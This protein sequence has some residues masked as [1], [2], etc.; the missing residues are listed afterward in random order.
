MKKLLVIALIACLCSTAAAQKSKRKKGSGG[1]VPTA[2]KVIKSSDNPESPD[3]AG[4]LS[5][6]ETDGAPAPNANAPKN[7]KSKNGGG[8]AIAKNRAGKSSDNPES[9]DYAGL[10]PDTKAIAA[11]QR[12]SIEPSEQSAV[13][14]KVVIAPFSEPAGS[15]GR[16]AVLEIFSEQND[17]EMVG[18]NDAEIVAKRL[19][20][21]LGS[22]KGRSVVSADMG[23]YAW[24]DGRVGDGFDAQI[25][26]SDA[27]SRTL[28]NAQIKADSAQ[29]LASL[30]RTDLWRQVGPEIS[31]R[32]KLQQRYENQ[33]QL[34]AQT[35]AAWQKE[36]N[37]QGELAVQ[38]QQRRKEYL[39]AAQTAAMQK[40]K[41]WNDQIAHQGQLAQERKQAEALEARR[42]QEE[43]ARQA[44]EMQRQQALEQQRQAA[45][46]QAARQAA[47]QEAARQ[48]AAEQAAR[49]QAA[50]QAALQAQ[51]AA[52]A[53]YQQQP[54]YQQPVYQQPVYRQPSAYQQPLVA[55]QGNAATA[56]P[57]WQVQPAQNQGGY[58]LPSTGYQQ[59][60]AQ[61]STQPYPAAQPAQPTWQT[62]GQPAYQQ[63]AAQS[64]TQT[65]WQIQPQP[66]A[67]SDASADNSSPKKAR[68]T[69]KK[70]RK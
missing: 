69:K 32:A 44:A 18:Y 55:G 7:K 53:Q 46:E 9:P 50:R 3:F 63:P 61:G 56:Q 22:S 43:A 21:D 36:I 66:Y 54:V 14:R 5:E 58:Q 17:I 31:D 52:Q 15:K 45:A 39:V 38:R 42:K 41:E 68:G 47:A 34:A 27:N 65:A 29:M 6:V 11:P 70:K 24:L 2:N 13:I 51:W 25:R 23:I 49:D 37:R 48:A 12:G 57:T 35:F 33:C 19:G 8:K 4:L 10:P 1:K 30:I 16:E 26:L 28:K 64:G 59:G 20:A 62:Q 40:L 67:L 60:L